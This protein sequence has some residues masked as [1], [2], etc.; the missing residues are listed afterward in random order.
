VTLHVINDLL[1]RLQ[2]FCTC[3]TEKPSS[4]GISVACWKYCVQ[5]KVMKYTFLRLLRAMS[6]QLF[7]LFCLYMYIIFL[8]F[9]GMIM[10]T[11]KKT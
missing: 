9:K 1:R 10:S 7:L 5:A 6:L 3:A 11:K 8:E 4:F 2:C